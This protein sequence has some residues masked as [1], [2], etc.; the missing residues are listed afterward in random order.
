MFKKNQ[1]NNSSWHVNVVWTAKMD[2]L[3]ETVWMQCL[4][5]LLQKKFTD[6]CA[7]TAHIVWTYIKKISTMQCCILGS[8]RIF[9]DGL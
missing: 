6:V 3:T 7:E 4:K 8:G 2:Y 5:Y 1:E 9:S